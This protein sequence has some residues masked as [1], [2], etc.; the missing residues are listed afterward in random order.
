M[1]YMFFGFPFVLFSF[2]LGGGVIATVIQLYW[3]CL[4]VAIFMSLWCRLILS[5]LVFLVC[6]VIY[7]KISDLL[8][9]DFEYLV[10]G[11]LEN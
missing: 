2:F 4:T 6:N 10:S 9:S 11:K 1:S 8:K 3:P 7:V 5:S